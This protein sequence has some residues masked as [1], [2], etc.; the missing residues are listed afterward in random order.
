MNLPTTEPPLPSP[1][2]ITVTTEFGV[3]EETGNVTVISASG[4]LPS[5]HNNDDDEEEGEEEEED[6]EDDEEEAEAEDSNAEMIEDLHDD[7]HA[8]SLEQ[9]MALLQHSMQHT[10]ATATPQQHSL[11]ILQHQDVNDTGEEADI[12]TDEVDADAESAFIDEFMQEEEG[13]MTPTPAAAASTI[14]ATSTTAMTT[15][16]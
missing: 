15:G 2:S 9:H 16:N 13:E 3:L 10:S 12:D 8:L 1:D 14:T 7:M 4:P 6:E 5:Y 11:H